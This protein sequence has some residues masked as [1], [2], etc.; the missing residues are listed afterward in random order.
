MTGKQT[1]GRNIQII[2]SARQAEAIYEKNSLEIHGVSIRERLQHDRSSGGN[3][4][5]G[6]IEACNVYVTL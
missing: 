1:T 3:I 6:S 4:E 5:V 2:S